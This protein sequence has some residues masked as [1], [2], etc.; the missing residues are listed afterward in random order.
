M[1]KEFKTIDEQ[2]N[3]LK[4]RGLLFDEENEA[5]EILLRE[6]YFFLSGY[7]HLFIMRGSTRF[8]SGTT[9]R[10]LHSLFLFDRYCFTIKIF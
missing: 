8:I 10:E 6:N 5:K 1:Q 9:F 2:I 3:I 4:N 7:R